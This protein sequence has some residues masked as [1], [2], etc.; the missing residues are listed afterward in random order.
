L[1]NASWTRSAS[2]P[3]ANASK[4][5]ENVAADGN[6][7]CNG[8]PQIRRK[9]RSIVRRSSKPTV[10][11]IPKTALAAKAFASQARSCGGRPIPYHEDVTNASMRTHSRTVHH[12]LQFWRQWPHSRLQ[13]RE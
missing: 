1:I 5:R 3:V 13:F 9:A 11:D 8:K 12:L 10:V 7:W 4:A 6:F 2:F